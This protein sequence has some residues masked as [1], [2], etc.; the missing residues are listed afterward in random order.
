MSS[1][2][3]LSPSSRIQLRKSA[4]SWLRNW[5]KLELSRREHKLRKYL[6]ILL[7]DLFLISDWWG[8]TQPIVGGAIPGSW[9]LSESRLSKPW[10]ESL[11]QWPLHQLMSPTSYPAWV[12]FLTSFDDEVW[13][14][15]VSWTNPFLPKFLWSWCSITAIVTLAKTCCSNSLIL[16]VELTPTPSPV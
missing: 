1:S 5:H 10:R 4:A 2:G 14:E 13:C 7:R 16:P 12:P 8:R 15:S 11:P 6:K 9:V 3:Q